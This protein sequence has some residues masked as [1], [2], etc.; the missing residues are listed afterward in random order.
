LLPISKAT[1]RAAI[2]TGKSPSPILRIGE[3]HKARNVTN[4][5]HHLKSPGKKRR[6]HSYNIVFVDDFDKYVIRN[7]MGSR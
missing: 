4:L 6:K 1:Q 7:A 3:K 2:Y 5:T